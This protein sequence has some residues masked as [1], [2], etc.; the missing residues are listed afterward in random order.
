MLCGSAVR[1]YAVSVFNMIF[2]FVFCAA[3]EDCVQHDGQGRQEEVHQL[4][5]RRGKRQRSRRFD[6]VTTLL[7]YIYK[8]K[9]TS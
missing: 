3:G 2:V 4:P 8:E 6:T 7:N 5:G 9:K 1:L